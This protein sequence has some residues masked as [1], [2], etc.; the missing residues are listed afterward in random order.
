[1]R[2]EGGRA[3]PWAGGRSTPRARGNCALGPSRARAVH[4]S[5]VAAGPRPRVRGQ[6][7][8]ARARGNRVGD[9]YAVHKPGARAE[10]A[11][12][13]RPRRAGR[14]RSGRTHGEEGDM[15]EGDGDE[16]TSANPEWPAGRQAHDRA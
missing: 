13:G 10:P 15:E 9:G 16:L 5:E 3:T 12:A 2:G 7:G 4:S 1:V 8:D 6:V 11:A 14:K